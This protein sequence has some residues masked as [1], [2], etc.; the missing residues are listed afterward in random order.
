MLIMEQC[1]PFLKASII[2]MCVGEE[3]EGQCGKIV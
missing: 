2:G 1:Q 3:C